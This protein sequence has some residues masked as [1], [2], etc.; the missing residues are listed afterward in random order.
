[1]PKDAFTHRHEWPHLWTFSTV[2]TASDRRVAQIMGDLMAKSD[3]PAYETCRIENTILSC[4]RRTI[5]EEQLYQYP[6]VRIYLAY[7]PAWSE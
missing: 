7:R 2:L 1:M 4:Q 5:A 3:R 6:N